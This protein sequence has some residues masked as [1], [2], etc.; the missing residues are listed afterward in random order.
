VDETTAKFDLLKLELQSIQAGIRGMDTIM[1]QIKGWCVTVAVAT[2]GVAL[3]SSHIE[4]VAVGGAAVVGFWLVDA[5]YKSMQRIFID[6]D[7]RIEEILAGQEPLAALAAGELHVPGLASSFRNPGQSSF[8][9][10]L[11]NE[12]GLLWREAKIPLT[13]GLYLFI[14]VLLGALALVDALVR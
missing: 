10:N 6:R 8:S 4:L 9:Q 11:Q 2:A 13:F 7:D 3:T 14:L 12:F 1:F 5:H